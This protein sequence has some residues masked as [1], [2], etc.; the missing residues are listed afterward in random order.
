MIQS[1]HNFN[2]NGTD[3]P[4]ATEG[5][6]RIV[7]FNQDEMASGKGGRSFYDK[8]L[9]HSISGF[10]RVGTAKT[11][12]EKAVD[13]IGV[14]SVN[15]DLPARKEGLDTILSK[16]KRYLVDSTTNPRPGGPTKT[17]KPIK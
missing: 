4:E 14:N 11:K 15:I 8:M 16:G 2:A 13:V 6:D 5:A 1:S 7:E 3:A 12:V 9:P 10:D 17:I